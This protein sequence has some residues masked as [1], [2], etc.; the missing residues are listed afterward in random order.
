LFVLGDDAGAAENLE[1]AL[2]LEPGRPEA[3]ATVEAVHLRTG[4]H[5]RLERLYRSQ[6]ARLGDARAASLW[7][8]LAV[9]LRDQRGDRPGARFAL[10]TY[11]RLVPDDARAREALARIEAPSNPNAKPPSSD[12]K[13]SAAALRSAWHAN[14]DDPAFGKAL[15]RL[16][17]DGNRPDAALAAASAL[18]ARGAA[19][20]EVQ[21]FARRYRT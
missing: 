10:E 14:P 11:L 1:K 17:L 8:D 16:H 9:L 6:I 20:D 5:A 7:W 12:W 18:I 4:Q 2:Q 21:A 19:D 15:F 13:T 3:L